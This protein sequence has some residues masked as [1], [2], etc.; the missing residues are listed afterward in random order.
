M[1]G[2]VWDHHRIRVDVDQ[3]G[4]DALRRAHHRAARHGQRAVEPTAHDH[5]AVAFGIQ[6]DILVAHGQLGVLLDLEGG[7]I[8]MTGD[9]LKG[10]RL[11]LGQGEGDH[12]GAVA[13]HIIAP[14]GPQMPPLSLLQGLKARKGTANGLR[15]VK[16]GGAFLNKIDQ[17]PG[18]FMC[19]TKGLLLFSGCIQHST[20]GRNIQSV[21]DK[22]PPF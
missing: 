8:G 17:A 5:A 1:D 3:Y 6:A 12:A 10:L 15:R 4:P 20:I 13:R 21:L 11:P 18:V 9:Q 16:A 14:A 19:H 2:H 7:R 22:E